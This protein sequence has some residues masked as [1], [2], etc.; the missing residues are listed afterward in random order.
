MTDIMSHLQY[1]QSPKISHSDQDAKTP[2]AEAALIQ[3]GFATDPTAQ[4]TVSTLRVP[5]I[6]FKFLFF[7]NSIDRVIM[8]Y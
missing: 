6:F 2:A 8:G 3:L 1:F 7:F 4:L 5:D